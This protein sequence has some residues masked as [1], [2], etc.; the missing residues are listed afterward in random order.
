MILKTLQLRSFRNYQNATLHFHSGINFIYGANAQGKTNL[1]ESIY[2]LSTTNSHHV[3]Q[4]QILIQ[5]HQD[6]FMIDGWI[7]KQHKKLHLRIVRNKQGKHLMVNK[8]QVKKNS[9]FL[10]Q[11]NA[12]MFAPEDIQLFSATPRLRRRFIDLELSKVSLLYLQ[13]LSF[14]E[15]LVKER[16]AYL[17]KGMVDSIYLSTIDEQMAAHMVVIIQQR[18]RF[19]EALI[20]HA[21]TFYQNVANDETTI[22]FQYL[23]F[24]SEEQI[25]TLTKEDVIECLKKQRDKD[26]QYKVTTL[27]IHKDDFT[28]LINGKDIAKYGSQGQKRTLLLALKLGLVLLIEE[29]IK[30]YPVL[31]LDDVFSELDKDRRIAVLSQL[32][33]EV[34]IFISTTDKIEIEGREDIYYY[35][36]QAGVVTVR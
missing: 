36:V 32:P 20:R 27:G 17:K 18:H 19:L 24:I 22:G 10:G 11:F 31:L 15:K 33:K 3:N 25:E 29:I 9:L 16:N 2:Y 23:S 13:N 21:T 26:L 1:L 30:E 34:Q 14:Y 5:H 7:L 12:V 6:F 28:F 4:D 35:Q 8:Q